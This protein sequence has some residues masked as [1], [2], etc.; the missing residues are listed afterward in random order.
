[1]AD[2][3]G[4]GEQQEQGSTSGT[5][6]G[7]WG[8]F[9]GIMIRARAGVEQGFP[10]TRANR[11]HDQRVEPSAG[12]KRSRGEGIGFSPTEDCFEPREGRQSLARGVSPW[13]RRPNPKGF[14]PRRGGSARHLL[15]TAAPPGLNCCSGHGIQG[16]T[17]LANN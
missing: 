12:G 4:D 9:R 1:R 6:L 10:W 16:L 8:P 11:T 2:K 17:P 13:T 3:Q 5:R 14:E 7:P 15:D